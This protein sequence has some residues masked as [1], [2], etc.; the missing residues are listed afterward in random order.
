MSARMQEWRSAADPPKPPLC[1]ETP[2][3]RDSERGAKY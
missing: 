2:D 1:A 3:T